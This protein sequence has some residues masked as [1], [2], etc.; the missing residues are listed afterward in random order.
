MNPRKIMNNF[1]KI[2]ISVNKKHQS[3]AKS[4][5]R[6]WASRKGEKEAS[7]KGAKNAKV[8]FRFKTLVLSYFI[9]I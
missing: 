8:Y 5:T 3:P 4:L 9:A 7:R 6:K 2:T 1:H